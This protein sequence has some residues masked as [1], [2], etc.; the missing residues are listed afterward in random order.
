MS[1]AK[2]PNKKPA[3]PTKPERAKLGAAY[4]AAKL[5]AQKKVPV[6]RR[7]RY[8]GVVRWASGKSGTVVRH[9]GQGGVF[10]KIGERTLLCAPFNFV[11][12][13]PKP[14]KAAPAA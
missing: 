5:A 9:E 13:N 3:K 7:V 2:K 14:K 8:E 1:A 11:D 4:K 12:D 6:G 10:V